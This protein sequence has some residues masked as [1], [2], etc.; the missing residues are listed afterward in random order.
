MTRLVR[1]ML[2]FAVSVG[3]AQAFSTEIFAQAQPKHSQ[4]IAYILGARLYTIN[5]DGSDQRLIASDIDYGDPAWSPDGSQIAVQGWKSISASVPDVIYVMNADGSHIH[6]VTEGGAAVFNASRPAWSPDGQHILFQG[7]NR[8][9]GGNSGLFVIKTDGSERRQLTNRSVVVDPE[10][11]A[12]SPDG[13]QIAFNGS[14]ESLAPEDI[15]LMN[16]DGSNLHRLTNGAT[17]NVNYL[18]PAWSPDGKQIAFMSDL[19]GA[20]EIYT[21]TAYGKNIRH[22]TSNMGWACCPAWS[23]DG[24]QIAFVSA[25]ADEPDN[26]YVINIDGKGLRR[27]T[28]GLDPAWQP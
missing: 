16:A 12:W 18:H 1:V 11:A 26:V 6:A 25:L 3:L 10:R 13:S 7:F 23:P 27:V 24:T 5:I 15:Y 2:L 4:R 14:Q 19:D 21:M 20:Y 8:V 9:G 22:L 17:R 28:S